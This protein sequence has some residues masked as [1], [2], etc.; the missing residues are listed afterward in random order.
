[1]TGESSKESSKEDLPNEFYDPYS[2]YMEIERGYDNYGTYPFMGLD[3]NIFSEEHFFKFW[4]YL[5]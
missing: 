1:M 4:H 5:I 3:E 2:E